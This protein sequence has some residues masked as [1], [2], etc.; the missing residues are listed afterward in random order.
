MSDI[1]EAENMHGLSTA[2]Q[3]MKQAGRDVMSQPLPRD[4]DSACKQVADKYPE[5]FVLK[6]YSAL[7]AAF[8]NGLVE[9]LP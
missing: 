3:A 8:N 9:K 1:P 4:M 7:Q 6:N 5:S 2:C